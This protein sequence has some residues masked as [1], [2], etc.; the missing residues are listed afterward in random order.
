[1]V[2]TLWTYRLWNGIIAAIEPSLDANLDVIGM[3]INGEN[4]LLLPGFINA[5][6]HSSEMWLR[7]AI[8]PFPLELWA[9]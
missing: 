2:T 5:H 1:M 9:C 6:T 7:G 3:A 8:P 4:K